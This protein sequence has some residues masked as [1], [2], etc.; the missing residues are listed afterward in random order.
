[1][2]ADEALMRAWTLAVEDYTDEVEDEFE[3]LIPTLVEAGYAETD[4]WTWN[5]TDNGIERAEALEE[6]AE[7]FGA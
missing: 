6:G 3:I 1:V 4:G 7:T 5:F 2:T